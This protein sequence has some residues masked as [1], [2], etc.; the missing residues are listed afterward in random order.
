MI[1]PTEEAEIRAEELSDDDTGREYAELADMEALGTLVPETEPWKVT[2]AGEALAAVAG[3]IGLLAELEV[4]DDWPLRLAE[5]ETTED[6]VSRR[7]EGMD[8][9]VID[10]LA[11]YG[12]EADSRSAPDDDIQRATEVPLH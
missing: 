10:A 1:R 11:H 4:G 5:A 12:E 3:D 6:R 8:V 9:D 7:F 2:A